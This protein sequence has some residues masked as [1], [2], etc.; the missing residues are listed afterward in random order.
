MKTEK[1]QFQVLLLYLKID[2][3][4]C[5]NTSISVW[6]V[7]TFTNFQDALYDL[8][9][10]V[11][12]PFYFFFLSILSRMFGQIICNMTVGTTFPSKNH[13][14]KNGK[15][16]CELLLNSYYMHHSYFSFWKDKTKIQ[17]WHCIYIGWSIRNALQLSIFKK[18]YYICHV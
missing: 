6:T 12:T 4:I 7:L 8:K 16:P 14:L 11:R 10:T 5:S 2:R 3:Y 13:H 1:H 17:R 9:M 15:E 18:K